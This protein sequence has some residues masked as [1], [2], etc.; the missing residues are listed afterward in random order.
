MLSW[1]KKDLLISNVPL[2]VQGHTFCL[3]FK[4]YKSFFLDKS[5]KF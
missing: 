3:D 4:K 1:E 2:Q 5:K